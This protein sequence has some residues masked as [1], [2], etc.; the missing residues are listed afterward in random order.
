MTPRSCHHCVKIAEP[1]EAIH[2]A[3]VEHLRLRQKPGLCFF[4]VPNQGRVPVQ[5]RAKLKA[6]GLLPGVAD[7]IMIRGGKPFALE[8]KADKGRMS[9]SQHNFAQTWEAAGGYYCPAYGMDEALKVLAAW[10]LIR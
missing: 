7:L 9:V 2:K 5:Y 3:V 10:D 8:L 1:E 6:M 4:H